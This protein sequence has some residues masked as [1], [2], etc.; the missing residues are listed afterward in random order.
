MA[1]QLYIDLGLVNGSKYGNASSIKECII[2]GADPKDKAALQWAIHNKDC[3]IIA[4]IYLYLYIQKI[5]NWKEKVKN[6][7]SQLHLDINSK[8][9]NGESA[10][11]RASFDGEFK[12]VKLLLECGADVNITDTYNNTPLHIASAFNNIK[13]VNL[14]ISN[15]ANVNC[16]N[17]SRDTPLRKA[18]NGNHLEVVE[19]LLKNG[20]CMDDYIINYTI[21]T[22]NNSRLLGHSFNVDVLKILLE[23]GASVKNIKI[24]N[25]KNQQIKDLVLSYKKHEKCVVM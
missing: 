14:L 21:N 8:D 2:N 13:I 7:Y 6:Q 15:N 9:S 3:Y 23:N 19:I 10:L 11:Y 16:I 5:S 25:I 24:K 18:I 22:I 20:A 4:I 17:N 12:I 1:T